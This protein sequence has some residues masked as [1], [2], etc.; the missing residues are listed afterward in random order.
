MAPFKA[1]GSTLD[2]P[3]SP[4]NVARISNGKS[5]GDR[6]NE[7][8]LYVD[9]RP[10]DGVFRVHRD[11]YSDPELFDLEMKHIFERTWNFLAL[12][13]QIPKPHDFVTTTIGRTPVLVTRTAQGGISALLNM[14]R[15]KG[16]IV[17]RLEQGNARHH[18]CPYHGWV[19]DSTGKNLDIKDQAA[20]SYTPAF[21]GD[22]HNLIP[23][24]KLAS[25]KGLIFGSL[26]PDVPPLEDFLGD[27]KVFIDLAMDQGPHGMEFI[28]GRAAYTFNG[29]WK[30][31]LDNGLDAYHLTSTHISFMEIQGR[32]RVGKGNVEARQFDWDKRPQQKAGMFTFRNGHAAFWAHNTEPEKRPIYPVIDEI[33]KRVGE[34]RAQWMLNGRITS[35]FPNLQIADAIALMLRVFRPLSVNKTEMRSFCLAPIG[36]A[37]ELRDRRLRQFEDFFN[38]GG[39]A[40]PDDTTVYEDCQRGFVGEG[41]TWLQ[42]YSR[43][44]ASVTEGANEVARELGINPATSEIG[45]YKTQTESL[46][47]G[48]YREWLRLMTAGLE[49]RK[50]YP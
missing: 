19:Y 17:C 21:T 27:I 18:T 38:P 37:P 32:R 12:E 28:P 25:Y 26:S 40:T 48:P 15:H 5:G 6:R 34:A 42:G 50:A 20:A 33:K 29:N 11:V 31:Q 8:N 44:M 49:G 36:E 22:D 16:A 43:G 4:M 47:H 13:S 7:I 14:C 41:L 39:L 10:Q 46:L 45:T 3:G 35:I 30:L 1:G 9:D 24:A 2:E 23:L